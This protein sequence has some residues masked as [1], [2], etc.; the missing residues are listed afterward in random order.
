MV[1]V[2]M[3]TSGDD[4]S[5]LLCSQLQPQHH[6]Y[7][8]VC[9]ASSDHQNLSMWFWVSQ[10]FIQNTLKFSSHGRQKRFSLD[11]WFSQNQRVLF[12]VKINVS[13]KEQNQTEPALCSLIESS[14]FL[15]ARHFLDFLIKRRM[16]PAEN[17]RS[18]MNKNQP[19]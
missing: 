19:V 17:N 16:I 7:H 14:R 5:N 4:A 2:A 13:V 6:V 11:V 8:H 10:T 9:A 1:S 12:H 15:T 18:A 3:E